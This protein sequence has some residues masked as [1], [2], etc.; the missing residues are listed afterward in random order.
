MNKTSV[1]EL[2]SETYQ[3]ITKWAVSENVGASSKSIVN[4]LTGMPEKRINHP[5]DPSDLRRC[6]TLLDTVPEL[7]G[8]FLSHMGNASP[9]WKSLIADWALLMHVYRSEA[10]GRK[11][12]RTYELMKILINRASHSGQHL[13]F[14]MAK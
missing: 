12:E 5:H 3:K 11:A 6:V 13:P 10:G 8:P 9:A 7:L 1:P 2:S 14:M 4:Y